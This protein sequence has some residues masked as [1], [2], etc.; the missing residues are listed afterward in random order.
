MV[1]REGGN[2]PMKQHDSFESALNEA[3]R[4]ARNNPGCRFEV[5]ERI[6]SVRTADLVIEGEQPLPF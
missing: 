6:S 3:Q 2:P 4:L 1:W 5:L